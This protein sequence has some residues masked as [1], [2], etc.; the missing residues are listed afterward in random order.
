MRKTTILLVTALVLGGGLQARE[1]IEQ[2]LVKVN[3]E[4]LT[5]SDLELRQL[6][7]IRET[8]TFDPVTASEDD[9]KRAI[10][11]VTPL[12]L[13]DAVDEMLLMQR[14]RELGQSMTEAQFQS[15]VENL[16]ADNPALQTDEQFE[17]ALKQEGMTMDDLRRMFER[18]VITSRVQQLEI[19]PKITVTD[20]EARAYFDSHPDEFRTEPG[21]TLR[22]MLIRVPEDDDGLSVGVDD[23]AKARAEALH[24][25]AVDGE[26]FGQL[27][28]Q[29]SD[30]GSKANGG[31]IG[32]LKRE[33]LAGDIQ[34]LID[35]LR[36]GQVTDVIRTRQGYQFFK[37]ESRTESDRLTFEEARSQISQKIGNEKRVKEL[38]K[39]LD[40]LRGQAIIEWKNDELKRAYEQGLAQRA[41]QLEADGQ[42]DAGIN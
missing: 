36:P 25:Q 5:K 21:I 35:P 14:G 42:A 20:E 6:R 11:E 9:L 23:Q 39:Y 30:A 10:A 24:A 15:I 7:A 3:G 17:A 19:M 4:I 27:A 18:Q 16:R 34:R 26:D 28:A 38:D 37:L 41:A 12:L 2:I 1:I 8:G 22:E 31:L 40:T 32:P 33:E 13:A 29:N